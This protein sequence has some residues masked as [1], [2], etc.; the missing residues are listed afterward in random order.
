MANVFQWDLATAARCVHS[1]SG[2]SPI[3]VWH[4]TSA[5]IWFCGYMLCWPYRQKYCTRSESQG[6]FIS[7]PLRR[8]NKTS[9]SVFETRSPKQASVAP[10][11]DVCPSTKFYLKKKGPTAITEEPKIFVLEMST[12]WLVSNI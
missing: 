8:A 11:M 1:L 7:T 6:M 2:R 5:E 3:R 9:H 10:K 12:V 4:P